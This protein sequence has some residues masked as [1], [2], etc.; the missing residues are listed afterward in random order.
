MTTTNT[1][2]TSLSKNGETR[3]V[4]GLERNNEARNKKRKRKNFFM[5]WD[6]YSGKD[7]VYLMAMGLVGIALPKFILDETAAWK[8]LHI[9][10]QRANLTFVEPATNITFSTEVFLKDPEYSKEHTAGTYL[11][12]FISFCFVF[13][14]FFA[15]FV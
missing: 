6:E 10:G 5:L 15:I 7:L 13:V 12:Y 9:P 4:S 3:G 14:L 2:P 8:H 11:I 1:N